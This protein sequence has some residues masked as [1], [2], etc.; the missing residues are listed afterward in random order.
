MKKINRLLMPLAIIATLSSPISI[1]SS[2]KNEVPSKTITLTVD[3]G[4]HGITHQSP[5]ILDRGAKWSDVKSKIYKPSNIE[6]FWIFKTWTLNGEALEET[7]TFNEDSTIVA[8]YDKTTSI[9]SVDL[10]GVPEVI[11]NS[12]PTSAIEDY[13]YITSFSIP[14]NYLVEDK[15]NWDI[16]VNGVSI[17]QSQY[18]VLSETLVY[19]PKQ[20]ITG[21]ISITIK[22][23]LKNSYQVDLSNVPESIRDSFP[24]SVTEGDN[25][26][27]SFKIP[28]PYGACELANWDLKVNNV[29]IKN[30]EDVI[31][32]QA[33]IFIPSK[34]ITGT[35]SIFIKIKYLLL[36]NPWQEVIE[37]CNWWVSD[38]CHQT[39]NELEKLIQRFSKNDQQIQDKDELV[40]CL[41]KVTI[42]GKENVVR[43][44]DVARDK[45]AENE[46]RSAFL[47]FEMVNLLSKKDGSA[48][49]SWYSP[50]LKIYQDSILRVNLEKSMQP[51]L[52]QY[53]IRWVNS[54]DNRDAYTMLTDSNDGTPILSGNIKKIKKKEYIYY[55]IETYIFPLSYPEVYPWGEQIEDPYYYWQWHFN[56]N[57]RIKSDLKGI[58]SNY[59]LTTWADEQYSLAWCIDFDGGFHQS[60]RL[61]DTG[62][63][64]AFC[65]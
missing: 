58:A 15:D 3:G 22:I 47:T 44:I 20:Y 61:N 11:R 50:E 17:K 24:T 1:L 5:L 26:F 6:K 51:Q 33:T 29:S 59:W 12:F 45:L 16:K 4:E 13:D 60:S 46:D 9:Y 43:I 2:C 18:V 27:V 19:I 32:S 38:E 64:F 54:D 63:S 40:G 55:P 14:S 57:D 23:R 42:N 39:S 37:I 8:S 62:V 53:D 48:Y 10:S 65:V 56:D 52:A 25:Y 21:D 30:E 36:D 31:L 35:I 28:L 7:T 34:L 49:R 41:L